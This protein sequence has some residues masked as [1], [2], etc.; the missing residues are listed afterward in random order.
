METYTVLREFADSWFLIAMFTF[1]L[2]CC[3]FAFWPSQRRARDAAAAIVLRDDS[4]PHA[5]GC[6]NACPDC[7]CKTFLMEAETNG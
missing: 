1:F 4:P 5:T 3:A 2:G 7:T 6:A